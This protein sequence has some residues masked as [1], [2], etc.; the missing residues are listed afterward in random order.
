MSVTDDNQIFNKLEKSINSMPQ[1]EVY[2]LS[3]PE[4]ETKPYYKQLFP[5]I[6]SPLVLDFFKNNVITTCEIFECEIL[7]KAI[8]LDEVEW[9]YKL[10]SSSK[11]EQ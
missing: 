8:G 11:T 4:D 7:I 5:A 3:Q 10:V 1:W 2:Q 6:P 9:K